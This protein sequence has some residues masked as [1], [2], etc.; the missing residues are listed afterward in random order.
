MK[1]PIC[2]LENPSNSEKC[3]CGYNFK[4]GRFESSIRPADGKV[5]FALLLGAFSF[6]LMFLLGEGV[7]VPPSVPGAKYIEGILFIG[8][9]CGYFLISAYLLSRGNPQAIWKNWPIIL[10]LNLILLITAIIAL[11]VEPNKLAALLTLG[12]AI[13]AVACSFA[14]AWL[15]ARVA[16]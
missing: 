1:C 15:G 9:M 12:V 11:V 6:F 10:A 3:S 8:G 4:Y 5:A 2:K 16:H 7:S 14:G 13:V